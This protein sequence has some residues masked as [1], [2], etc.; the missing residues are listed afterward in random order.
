M[1]KKRKKIDPHEGCCYRHNCDK[2][3]EKC[4]YMQIKHEKCIIGGCD[5]K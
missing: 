2:N 1:M 4:C 3:L 5:E